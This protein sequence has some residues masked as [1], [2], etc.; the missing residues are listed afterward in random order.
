MLPNIFAREYC[1]LSKI[2][3]KADI[4]LGI[5]FLQMSGD[6]LNN[7]LDCGDVLLIE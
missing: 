2:A 5:D 3:V 4:F 7:P 6:E 1:D